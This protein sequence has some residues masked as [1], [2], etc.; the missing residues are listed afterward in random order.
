MSLFGLSHSTFY[1][2]RND[3]VLPPPDG[4]DGRRPYWRRDTVRAY[5]DGEAPGG[6]HPA[7]TERVAPLV[8]LWND[9]GGRNASKR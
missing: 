1:E 3:G 5:L 9:Q 8:S 2:R 4:Y 7:R 6:A